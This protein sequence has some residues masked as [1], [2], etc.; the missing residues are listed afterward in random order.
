MIA[1]LAVRKSG[2]KIDD[3][4]DLGERILSRI[5]YRT[6]RIAYLSNLR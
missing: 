5:G 3:F 4:F 2:H 6:L 1:R